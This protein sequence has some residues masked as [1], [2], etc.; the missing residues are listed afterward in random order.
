MLLLVSHNPD[1]LITSYIRALRTMLSIILCG[2]RALFKI[3]PGTLQSLIR[4]CFSGASGRS[5]KP[6]MT[7]YLVKT[8]VLCK[9]IMTPLQNRNTHLDLRLLQNSLV[10]ICFLK[11]SRKCVLLQKQPHPPTMICSCL[12][13]SKNILSFEKL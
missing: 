11:G 2:L 3:C 13:F 8:T 1:F 4:H 7:E 9:C 12:W 10:S 5:F 6:Q